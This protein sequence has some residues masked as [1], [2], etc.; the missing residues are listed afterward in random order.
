MFGIGLIL[1][2]IRTLPVRSSA[3]LQGTSIGG[4]LLLGLA[5]DH[6]VST[7]NAS[8][9]LGVAPYGLSPVL[10]ATAVL[11]LI[12]GSSFATQLYLEDT[13]VTAGE[14]LAAGGTHR[15]LADISSARRYA[16]SQ[17]NP[18]HISQRQLASSQALEQEALL[19]V[20]ASF[21]MFAGMRAPTVTARR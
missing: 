5:A 8:F 2:R 21:I 11:P 3:V 9:R 19:N 6:R 10:M 17:R 16:Q 7:I 14:A 18:G 20:E 15:V 1:D 4:G 12:V 13:R